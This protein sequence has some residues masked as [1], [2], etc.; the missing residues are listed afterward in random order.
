VF[1]LAGVGRS[2]FEAIS[3]RDYVV[4]QGFTLLIAFGYVMINLVVDISYGLLDPRIRL[5]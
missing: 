3:G 5:Q 2:L 1:N 4:I